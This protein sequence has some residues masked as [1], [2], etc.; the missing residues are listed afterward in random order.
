MKKLFLV[1][2]IFLEL[3]IYPL[4]AQF[5]PYPQNLD[6]KNQASLKKAITIGGSGT[7]TAAAGLSSFFLK[8]RIAPSVEEIPLRAFGNQQ[9][10]NV[11]EEALEIEE[12][13]GIT[14]P[15][16][17]T[18][19]WTVVGISLLVYTPVIGNL[20]SESKKEF[21]YKYS[22]T[23]EIGE[24]I[25]NGLSND[26]FILK[27]PINNLR[28]HGASIELLK[29]VDLYNKCNIQ[30]MDPFFINIFDEKGNFLQRA[31]LSIPKFPG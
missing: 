19:L 28:D 20:F 21:K 1:G 24:E 7:V 6:R 31:N 16:P 3:L 4:R 13:I 8:N 26:N 25:C 12:V 5:I 27:H 23:N 9:E 10:E 22:I 2:V 14:N 15:L 30:L 17:M 11:M 29:W 18:V